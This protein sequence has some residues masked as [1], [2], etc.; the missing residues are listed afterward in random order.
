MISD[1]YFPRV[2]G[3]STSIQ[4]FRDSLL[5]LG[6]D[7]HL[8]APQY[9]GEEE[10]QPRLHR[11]PAKSVPF[12]PEDRIMS[13]S[14]VCNLISVLHTEKPFDLI[15]IQT[16]FVAHKAGKRMARK[17]GVPVVETYHTHFE[18]YIHNYVPIIPG[19]FFRPLVRF[20]TRKQ[21][22]NLDALIVPSSPMLKVIQ[23]YGIEIATCILPTGIDPAKFINSNGASFRDACNI[24]P[25]QPVMLHIGRIA[26]EKNIDFLVHVHK[27]VLETQPE[28]IFIIAGEGPAL[29]HLKRLAKKLGTYQQSRFVGYLNRNKELLDCYAAGDVFVFSSKTE[30]QGLVLLEAMA[31]GVP[32]VSIAELGTRDILLQQRG[33][34]VSEEDVEKFSGL[35]GEVLTA[36]AVHKRMRKEG[37][38][39]VHEWSHQELSKSLLDFYQKIILEH[40]NIKGNERVSEQIIDAAKASVSD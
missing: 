13:V 34:V 31:S 27:K 7:V 17:F 37:Q 23:D 8:I 22:L 11:L 2:N 20:F 19:W 1:V 16:P 28:T 25:A 14:R 9:T 10:E 35:V 21:C 6:H 24:K 29:S 18:E 5:Q 15:H 39:F 30:T 26:H 38:E 33:A 12:D 36:P 40:K 4:T 3:V 32:I